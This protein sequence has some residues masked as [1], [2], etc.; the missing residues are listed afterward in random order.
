MKAIKKITLSAAFL[1]IS[2][3]GMANEMDLRIIADNADKSLV[4]RYENLATDASLR[5]IDGE[6]NVIFT[7]N[8][9][10]KSAYVKRFNLNSLSTGTYFLT[11]EDALK[12]TAYTITIED[13][14]ISIENK[15]V[16]NKPVFKKVDDMVYI[17]MLNLKRDKVEI[18]V[19]DDSDRVVFTEVSEDADVVEKAFN[20][21]KAY[22]GHYTIKVKK[23]NEI[24]YEGI[25][26]D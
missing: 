13:I 1:F 6:G 3:F 18:K 8:L 17:N 22:K 2:A 25:N 14:N 19:Y 24:Y 20:F 4:F 12:E 26:V 5:F 7:E 15:S 16:K 9:E 10:D 11:V 23:N 21:K